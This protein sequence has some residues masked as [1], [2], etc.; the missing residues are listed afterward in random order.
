MTPRSQLESYLLEILARAQSAKDRCSS[1][2]AYDFISRSPQDLAQAISRICDFLAQAAVAI[3]SQIDWA[4]AASIEADLVSLRTADTL[5]QRWAAHLRYIQGAK[6]DRLPWGIVPSFESLAAAL[7]PDKQVLL[8]PKWNYNYTV[9]LSDFRNIYKEGL[10]EFQDVLPSYDI[11]KDVLG[12]LKQPFHI[13]AFPSLEREN[14]LLHTLLGHELGHL[15]ADRFLTKDRKEAFKASVIDQVESITDQD[16]RRAGL[17]KP[18]T[19]FYDEVLREQKA[20]NTE[21]AL[22]YW[23]R[24]LEEL[25]SD[26]VGAILF[27]PAALFSTLEMAI[28]QE[29]DI[30]PSPE[31]NFYPP[32]RMRLREVLYIVETGEKAFFPTNANLFQ[33]PDA[34]ER[35]LRINEKFESVQ[36]LCEQKT[37]F[38]KISEP[39]ARL[40]YSRVEAG[41]REGTSFLLQDAGLGKKG[42]RATQGVVFRYMRVLMD[43]LDHGIPPNALEASVNDRTR[44]SLVEIINAA[45]FHRASLPSSVL[46]EDGVLNEDL[47]TQRKRAN[48]LTL[49]AIEFA[50]LA[51]DYW[52]ANRIE[53]YFPKTGSAEV[54]TSKE[55]SLQASAKV[56]DREIR[57]AGVLSASEIVAC[58]GRERI[59]ER[60]VVTPLLNPHESLGAGAID[61]RLGNQFIVMKR[62]AFP[63]LDVGKLDTIEFDIEKFQEKVIRPFHE[64]FILQPGQ[65][66]IG[67]TLEYVQLP[68][69]LM[70]YVIGKSTWGRM[71]LIIAT[72]TK[73][74]PGFR[75]CITLEIIN[76]GEVPLVL[77]PGLPIAQLVLHRTSGK[78]IYSG[79]YSCAIGPEFPKFGGKKEWKYWT[80]SR[81]RP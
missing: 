42:R 25:L 60:L 64:E 14:I 28:Q 55:E 12:N 18:G 21:L 46:T 7:V 26:V 17:I 22:E 8:R 49:K 4:D 52:K 32:W 2:L 63:L 65:L 41:V 9:T 40:A 16:L 38:K 44:V 5:I 73:V 58:M 80:S 33:S 57:E 78:D 59:R 54:L 72:A 37:D 53:D 62:E 3:F 68:P 45:W 48:R 20:Y 66:V 43:R 30:P 56:S 70:C 27:G 23:T 75:G 11:E 35:A 13:I 39:I 69:D 74:D 47:V 77:Y 76:E 24:A 19:L 6:T 61:V 31:T 36:R 29:Y 67:S 79:G 10:E 71:G 15:F 34:S 50:G 1:L 81:G 51:G